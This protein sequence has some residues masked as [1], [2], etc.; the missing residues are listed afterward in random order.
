MEYVGIFL[1]T[2]VGVIVVIYASDWL[3]RDVHK[4]PLFTGYR[5]NNIPEHAPKGADVPPVG[6]AI[7]HGEKCHCKCRKCL[8]YACVDSEESTRD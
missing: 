3:A 7:I 4:T 5:A 1:L 2:C 8:N 6:G